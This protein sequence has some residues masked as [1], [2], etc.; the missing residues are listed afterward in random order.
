MAQ[1]FEIVAIGDRLPRRSAVSQTGTKEKTVL[2]RSGADEIG[3]QARCDQRS[4]TEFE[5]ARPACAWALWRPM[6]RR[7]L[8]F[9]TVMRRRVHPACPPSSLRPDVFRRDARLDCALAAVRSDR[10][11]SFRRPIFY[12]QRRTNIFADDARMLLQLLG[13]RSEE[14]QSQRLSW[15]IFL[16]PTNALLLPRGSHTG[17]R[18]MD[19]YIGGPTSHR[20]HKRFGSFSLFPRSTRRALIQ[21]HRPIPQSRP[22]SIVSP[23]V[24]GVE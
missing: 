5:S 13:R 4:R 9:E 10:P 16:S 12:R 22:A 18:G 2:R 6:T 21:L 11:R 17:Q 15:P 7:I 3:D 23:F 24:H 1:N 20:S 19:E 14:A 8:R